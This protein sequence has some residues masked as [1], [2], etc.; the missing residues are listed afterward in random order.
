MFIPLKLKINPLKYGKTD[1][2]DIGEFEEIKL[3]FDNFGND[4]KKLVH[5]FF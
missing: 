3:C 4:S 1:F 2:G 5:S